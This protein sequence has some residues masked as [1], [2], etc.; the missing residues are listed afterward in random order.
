MEPK[1]TPTPFLASSS[2]EIDLF[3]L[4]STL[5]KKRIIIFSFII[6]SM[7]CGV[8]FAITTTEKWTASA[9]IT[10]PEKGDVSNIINTIEKLSTYGVSN[11]P[12]TTDIYNNFVS[13]FNRY[14]NKV[15]FLENN[16][17]GSDLIQNSYKNHTKNKWV[18]SIEAKPLDRNALVPSITISASAKDS[19][20][21]LNLLNEY[22]AYIISI[23]KKNILNN[24]KN[25]RDSF[26]IKKETE[27]D[28]MLKAAISNKKSELNDLDYAF[29][30]AKA[31]EIVHPLTNFESSGRFS[32]RLGTKGLAEKISALNQMQIS[33]YQPELTILKEAIANVNNIKI[34]QVEFKPFSYLQSPLPPI[35]KDEP[36]QA[37]IVILSTI[38]GGILGVFVA[39]FQHLCEQRRYKNL[40]QTKVN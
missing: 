1:N 30:I 17:L 12:T 15:N 21:A 39:L 2:D 9:I 38:F 29:K 35:T 3:E 8:F 16:S 40:P 34:P 11:L 4:M 26:L 33:E 24:I 6:V 36:K 23:E 22:I 25:E 7:L 31:A 19:D 32:I 27:Y 20:K 5:W 18:N 10:Q 13:E 28:I 37:I 14:D